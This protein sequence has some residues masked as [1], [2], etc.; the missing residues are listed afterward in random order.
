MSTSMNS[1][2]NWNPFRVLIVLALWIASLITIA[3]GVSGCGI[4]APPSATAATLNGSVALRWTIATPI[5]RPT[6]CEQVN[7]RSIALR[8]RNRA[9]GAMVFAAIPCQSNQGASSVPAGN[10]DVTIELRASDGKVLSGAP[11][12]TNVFVVA[13]QTRQLAPVTFRPNN[14][15]RLRTSVFAF[16]TFPPSNC[17]DDGAQ[18]TG[19]TIA[20]ERVDDRAGCAI[21]TFVRSNRF[22]ELI[23][24]Y[25]ASDCVNPPVTPCVEATEF[26]DASLPAGHYLM[27][28]IGKVRGTRDCWKSDVPIAIEANGT[29]I[30]TNRLSR[31]NSIDC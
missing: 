17:G 1:S 12:Q 16:Q 29:T 4:V 6:T 25:L 27:H 9:T 31:Q 24:E 19:T 10:Y 22:G 8:L 30:V 2:K 14:L 13:G 21:T 26:L 15:G 28:V 20:V 18:M 23:G 11:S 5:L 7:A 3:V